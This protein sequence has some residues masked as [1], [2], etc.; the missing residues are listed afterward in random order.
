MTLRTETE[1]ELLFQFVFTRYV[2]SFLEAC[3]GPH[4][5]PKT[6]G[7]AGFPLKD[8]YVRKGPPRR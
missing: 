8:A 7:K 6:D 5:S 2:V 3:N 1:P 4:A